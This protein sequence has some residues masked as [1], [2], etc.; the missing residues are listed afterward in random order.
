MTPHDTHG[1]EETQ[2]RGQVPNIQLNQ[3]LRLAARTFRAH[4]AFFICRFQKDESRITVPAAHGLD[5]EK[6]EQLTRV[7]LLQ[8][9]PGQD[10]V[11]TL[12]HED[13]P[14]DL[15]LLEKI[16][17]R[18]CGLF[19]E[20]GLPFSGQE[21]SGTLCLVWGHRMRFTDGEEEQ[22]LRDF[23]EIAVRELEHQACDSAK[24]PQRPES[25]LDAT[26]IGLA[27]RVQDLEDEVNG[28]ARE[29]GRR[30]PYPRLWRDKP[31]EQD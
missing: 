16:T 7:P 5:H 23:A 20:V 31:P 21:C 27:R 8:K 28:L 6:H 12:H 10:I 13:N 14:D 3:I 9:A 11:R 22:D 18:D 26:T 15:A 1:I 19:V 2:T 29:L 25:G 4:A 17:G 24:G 30:T